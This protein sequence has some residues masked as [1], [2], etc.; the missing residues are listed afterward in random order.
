MANKEAGRP[1]IYDWPNRFKQR[2]F[3]MVRGKDYTCSQHSI[4]VQVRAAASKM[5][6]SAKVN[7]LGT[8]I[9]VTVTANMSSK[10]VKA[11]RELEQA[12]VKLNRGETDPAKGHIKAALKE[13]G[14]AK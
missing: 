7:D 3:T 14:G 6:L 10:Q 9:E 5:G 8:S 4:N 13:L 2:N 11:S 1:P 12:Q